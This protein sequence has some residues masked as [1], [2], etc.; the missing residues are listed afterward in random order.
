VKTQLYIGPAGW[1]YPDWNGI[2][3]PRQRPRRFDYLRYL[4]TYFNLIEINSTFYRIPDRS[5]C[6]SW[7]RRVDDRSDFQ[8][9]V[10]LF[11][12]FTHGSSPASSREVDAFRTAIEPLA[13][14]NRLSSV[15]VQFPWSF[16]FSPDTTRYV[17]QLA[18]WLGPVRPVVEV[19]HGSWGSE[20]AGFFFDDNDIAMCGI[21]QPLIGN[22]LAPDQFTL[23]SAGAYFR[24]H[25]RNRT[26][27]FSRTTN[28]DRRYDYMYSTEELA[29]WV[30]RI[31]G[32]TGKAKRIH[33]VLNNHFRGQAVANAL[34]IQS[35]ISGERSPAP[36]GILETYPETSRHLVIQAESNGERAPE[37]SGQQSL[38]ENGNR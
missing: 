24:L 29:G 36:P 20:E 34:A 10:K 28:R 31:E 5:I 25:G 26:E 17:S 6:A 1:S 11:R 30:K 18:Q 32:T 22:S 19:R 38:F 21:D 14:A 27:W 23:N 9:S 15:L 4:A 13:A 16:R 8:F 12:E 3:Y 2:V 33:V 35:M 7:A 37:E